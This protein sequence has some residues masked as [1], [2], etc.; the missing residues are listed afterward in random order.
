MQFH[1]EGSDTY[2]AQGRVG[3]CYVVDYHTTAQT[4][5]IP[6]ATSNG[7]P[8]AT[9]TYFGFGL[10]TTATVKGSNFGVDAVRYGTGA[11]LTAGE[12]L[13]AGDASDNP[14]TFAGFNAQNDS[15]NNRWGILTSVGG[16]NYELQGRF[17]IGQNNSKTATACSFKDSNK[18]I[19]LVDTVH[20]ASD[21]TQIILDHADTWVEWDNISI[22][23]LGQ[24]N[25][26]RLVVNSANPEFQ[27]TG[28]TLTEIGITTLRSNTTADGVTWRACGTVTANGATLAN[29]SIF[30]G[31]K[32]IDAQDETSYDNSPTTEG[33][34]SGGTGHVA[35][36]VLILD[37]GTRIVVDAVS[38]GV[39]TQF[40][41]DSARSKVGEATL[42]QVSS[43]GTGVDF[44]LTPDTA[45]YTE[46]AGL[47]WNTAA[48]PNGELDNMTFDNLTPPMTH[49]IEFG[50]TSPLT[51]TLT[52]CAF[53]TDY[54]ATEDGSV[55]NETFHFKRTSGTVT[56]NLNG[57]TGNFGYKTDGATVNIVASV[58]A[59]VS[60]VT[61]GTPV[62]IHAKE[63]L[64]AVTDGDLLSSQFADV[65]GEI[66][67]SHNDQGSLDVE[68]KARNQGVAT[69]CIAEDNGTGFT[70]ETDEGSSAI[71]ADMTLLPATPAAND[72]YY[73]GHQ[74]EFTRLKLD[75][76]TALAHSVQ[77]TIVWEY[78]DGTNWVVLREPTSVTDD[79]ERA[80][81]GSNW[82]DGPGWY[83]TVA[84][85]SGAIRAS[86]T[87]SPSSGARYTATTLNADQWSEIEI[88]TLV[89]DGNTL[90]YPFVRMSTIAEGYYIRV[91]QDASDASL[92][93]WRH[94]GGGSFTAIGT[95]YLPGSTISAGDVV[96][97]EV[98]GSQLRGYLNGVLFDTVT[99][100]NYTSGQPGIGVAANTAVAD[101]E[102]ESWS[103]GNMLTGASDFDGTSGL[104]TSG[105]SI[106]EWTLPSGWT[107]NSVTGQLNTGNMFYV[108]ARLSVAG[109][110]TTTPVGRKVQLD[111][112][113][114]LPFQAL[115]EIV[116]G[117]GLTVVA[118]WRPDTISKFDVND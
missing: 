101:A 12:L 74:E 36:D 15:I 23:A 9:P 63:T 102:I 26:G 25:P 79:F 54:S 98:V 64:G 110:I 80:S 97:L 116:T 13:S 95:D 52:D 93:I 42:S 24:I 19:S 34:F 114:Y 71:T 1:V 28:G 91:E 85:S 14:A 70:D 77:P 59:K 22:T 27:Y 61:R 65:N 11:Y 94:D 96:R 89:N 55:G 105:K 84:I 117:S 87:G 30:H 56:L 5:K 58:T 45:N 115:R 99:D 16:S 3:K 78:W 29:S 44:S 76:S 118:E 107:A 103:A 75:V 2:G 17:V 108:R 92:Q 46:S 51:M 83:N 50:L 32:I 106:V 18:N 73:F 109:T 41:V 4:G 49:A 82:S 53:G 8:G 33:T 48:D 68:I 67:Y 88:K 100:T 31:S 37:D 47:I 112:G 86:G 57:C 111:T 7:T 62:T 90:V 72:A 81:I 43:T 104:E 66:S 6:Y 38:G 39:V 21:F 40:T 69:A 10:K 20:A 113:R 35:A 60:G